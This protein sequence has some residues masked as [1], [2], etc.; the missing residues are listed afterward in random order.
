VTPEQEAKLNRIVEG[1]IPWV[2]SLLQDSKDHGRRITAIEV[3]CAG[4]GARADRVD[5]DL[6]ALGAK[7]RRRGDHQNQ[8]GNMMEW[9][10]AAVEFLAAAPTAIHVLLVAAMLIAGALGIT[11]NIRHGNAAHVALHGETK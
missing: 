8:H 9:C 2:E 3:N 10:M 7:I 11:I 6:M 1:R 5:R 4:R